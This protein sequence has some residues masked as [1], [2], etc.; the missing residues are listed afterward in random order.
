MNLI[1]TIENRFARTPDGRV[2]TQATFA[3]PFW[4]RYL[5]VFDH[6]RVV[7]R[8][9]AVTSVPPQWGRADGAQ[10]SFEPVPYYVGPWQYILQARRVRRS[11]E[12]AI[13][14]DSDGAVIMRVGSQIAATVEPLLRS[15]DHPYGLEVIGD[16]FNVFSPGALNHPLR[17]FFRWSFS[18]Q[19]RRQ[20]GG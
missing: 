2:W 19:L 15:S 1:V 5:T 4:M 12:N 8:V 20:C 14:S 10:V 13:R 7:A 3:Y 17:P 9:R 18:R 16:P 6:V 11:I